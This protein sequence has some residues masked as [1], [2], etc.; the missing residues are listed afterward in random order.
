[1]ESLD[2][3][4]GLQEGDELIYIGPA[5]NKENFV[6]DQVYTVRGF[7]LSAPGVAMLEDDGRMFNAKEPEH[8]KMKE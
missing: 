6:P 7:Y 1:M 4:S 3:S 8:F 2:W 5:D